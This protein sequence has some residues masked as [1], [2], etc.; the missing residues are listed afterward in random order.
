MEVPPKI[1]YR[2]TIGSSSL[3]PGHISRENSNLKKYMQ[4]YVHCSTSHNSQDVET[5]QMLTDDWIRKTW[6]IYTM[7]HY[8]AIK[9]NK[10]M[11][12]AAT[13]MELET[14]ILSEMSQKDKDKYH[15]ISL[16]TGI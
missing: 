9:K 1:Q 16:I 2:T 8:S 14:L 3:T 13:W 12:F 11:P 10:I 5:T 7:E 4:P 15:M 6:Y